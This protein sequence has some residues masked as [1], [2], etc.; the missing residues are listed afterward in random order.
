VRAADINACRSGECCAPNYC[1]CLQEK[2]K[3]K[4]KKRKAEDEAEGEERK[5]KVRGYSDLYLGSPACI[6]SGV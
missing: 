6:H 4:D 1:A 5:K 3:K 2:K